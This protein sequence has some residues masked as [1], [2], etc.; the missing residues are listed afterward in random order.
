MDLGVQESHTVCVSV[1]ICVEYD[2]AISQQQTW[3][4]PPADCI[5]VESLLPPDVSPV[6][7]LRISRE[8]ILAGNT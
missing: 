7:S 1:C 4:S 8:G 3:A 5:S 2:H 6:L